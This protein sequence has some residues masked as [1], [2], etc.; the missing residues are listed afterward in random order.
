[1]QYCGLIFIFSEGFLAK[2]LTERVR[3]QFGHPIYST[4]SRLKTQHPEP[5]HTI[6]PRIQIQRPMF[7]TT[8]IARQPPDQR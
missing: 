2:F 3:V 7:K 8:R 4:R 5:V 1:M 6:E